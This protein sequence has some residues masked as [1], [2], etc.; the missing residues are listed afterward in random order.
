MKVIT[1]GRSILVH[2]CLSLIKTLTE[3]II[4]QINFMQYPDSQ[5]ETADLIES[6]SNNNGAPESFFPNQRKG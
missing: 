1:L 5:N 3:W 2:K 6:N 4:R